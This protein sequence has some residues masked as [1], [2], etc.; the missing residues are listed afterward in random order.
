[1]LNN[2]H[3]AGYGRVDICGDKTIRFRYQL[4]DFDQIIPLHNRNGRLAKVL[5]EREDQLPLGE[6]FH[7]RL[8]G[9]QLLIALRMDSSSE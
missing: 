4:T 9:C 8:I 7:Q 6:V 2:F 5:A 3:L 1:M